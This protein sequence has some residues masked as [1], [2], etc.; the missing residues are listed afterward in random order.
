VANLGGKSPIL[1]EA[2]HAHKV[3]AAHSRDEYR[4]LPIIRLRRVG[5]KHESA[6]EL[7][8]RRL[9]QLDH[10]NTWCRDACTLSS[11][12]DAEDGGSIVCDEDTA[13]SGGAI[14]NEW[15]WSA[16][17]PKLLD[18]DDVQIGLARRRSRT[19]RKHM[20]QAAGP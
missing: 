16:G 19:R 9:A 14:Q 13:V 6:G 15:I 4:V 2:R 18:R 5:K 20:A 12:K 8:N 7:T 17:E 3:W 1:F 11:S 10:D